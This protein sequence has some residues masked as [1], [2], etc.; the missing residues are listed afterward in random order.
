VLLAVSNANKVVRSI[1]LRGQEMCVDI[2]LR[3]D[4]SFGF[5]EYRRDPED[6]GGW[7]A[8]GLFGSQ[9]FSSESD[10]LGAARARIRWLDEQLGGQRDPNPP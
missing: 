8:V 1:E 9:V 10:A 2:F 3:P 7:F 5:E 4:G 6:Q